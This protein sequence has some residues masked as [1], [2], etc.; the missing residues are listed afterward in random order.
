[1]KTAE[2]VDRIQKAINE[3]PEIENSTKI[4]VTSKKTG[5]LKGDEIHIIGKVTKAGDKER[6]LNIARNSVAKKMKVVDELILVDK[7][8]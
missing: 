5:L 6:A 7:D 8:I 2:Y 1:M 4:S 3:D